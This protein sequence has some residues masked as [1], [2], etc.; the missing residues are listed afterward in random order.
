[1]WALLIRLYKIKR[2]VITSGRMSQIRIL[3]EFSQICRE[4]MPPDFSL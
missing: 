4:M 1:M 2:F 3:S